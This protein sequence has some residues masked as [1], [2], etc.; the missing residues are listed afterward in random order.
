MEGR[1]FEVGPAETTLTAPSATQPAIRRRMAVFLFVSI[2]AL[3]L[4][5]SIA[6]HSPG[7]P[8]PQDVNALIA[9][10][11]AGQY[12]GAATAAEAM[13]RRFPR[14]P[15]G[16]KV[17]GAALKQLGRDAD[18]LAPMQKAVALAPENAE[19]QNNLGATLRDLGRLEEAAACSQ[20]ALKIRPDFAE[21]H[22]NLGNALT[23][24]GKPDEAVASYR[25]AL[26][27][28]PGYATAYSS[29]GNA[30]TALGRPDEAVVSCRRALE[31]E[32]DSAAA[33]VNLGLAL[34]DLGRLDDA[35]AS[36]RRSLELTPDSAQAH[37]N[38]GA[39][40]LDNLLFVRLYQPDQP[41]ASMLAEARRFGD[42][43]ARNARPYASWP[44]SPQPTRC[45]RV[46]LVSGDLCSH[47]VGYFLESMLP[48]LVAP[49]PVRLEFFGYPCQSR[50]DAVTARIKACCRGWHSAVGLND[51]RL[52]RRIREDGIDILVDLA[53][54][55]AHNRLP[56]FAWKPAPV[57]VSWLGYLATTG[58]TAIDY[59][60]A[61][62]WTLPES[63]AP[64]F[65][66][67]IWRLPESY[68]CFRPD[69][70]LPVAAT[71]ALANGYVTFGCFNN[72][73]KMN[74]AVIAQWARILQAVPGSRLFLKTKQLNQ[75]TSHEA[76]R[77]RFAAQGID[78]GRLVLEGH[79]PRTELLS[80]YGR[81]DIALDPFP[82]PG[83]TTTVEA[84]W[85]GVP[86][87]TMAGRHFLSRQG[88]G[89]ATHA[90]LPDWIATDADDYVA[91]AAA[92]AADLTNLAR[93]RG[94][95][96]E[97]LLKSPLLD[98][99]RFAGQLEAAL[100][101][102]WTQWCDGQNGN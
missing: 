77:A 6:T 36:F 27:F 51:E 41:A 43:V 91:K 85:M 93:L 86:V 78:A 90:G 56:M 87:L 70:D 62:P 46:G 10:F 61:D 60:I 34:Q 65:T 20:R 28:K 73:T 88:V 5:T 83:I 47:P 53:G 58:V 12:A 4:L 31:I 23:D 66:E 32:P 26:E 49:S 72:L 42:L 80:T 33:H 17:W 35:V 79:S 2:P 30:L 25:R 45:L 54:H 96:R 100:R 75:T 22:L 98:A 64:N 8:G 84:L 38:L 1:A 18:A 69:I 74:D 11:T 71:P 39:A 82:Y 68:L 81:V 95:L 55:T 97:Q 50:S 3:T 24:L 48:A 37:N 14:H 94:G 9:L 40:L 44:N 57:Q 13:T 67:K 99:P 59:V 92:H 16:W 7:N 76:V 101:G 15:F 63:D 89:I 52:A 29:M 19:A 21:A 102:M